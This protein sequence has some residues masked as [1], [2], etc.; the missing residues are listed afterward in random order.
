M[1]FTQYSFMKSLSEEY[2]FKLE[3]VYMRYGRYSLM[4]YVTENGINEMRDFHSKILEFSE[5][6]FISYEVNKNSDDL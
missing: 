3:L 5:K 1:E 6:Y 2:K 4:D